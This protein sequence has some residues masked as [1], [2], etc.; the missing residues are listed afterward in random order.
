MA[1][2]KTSSSSWY[3]QLSQMLAQAAESSQSKRLDRSSVPA[4]VALVGVGNELN[5]DDAAG[6]WVARKLIATRRFPAH[7]LAIDGGSLPENASG[8]LRRFQPDLVLL[9]DA[10]E[11][12]EP[13]GMIE[14]L[15]E[16]MIG[17]MS[18]SSHTLP[19]S[20]LGKYLQSELGCR[21]EYL[22]IQPL[23]IDY[24]QEMSDCVNEA[25]N[26]IVNEINHQFLGAE[27]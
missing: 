15:D 8:P 19:L 4:R 5:G 12:G 23:Q 11:L 22:G 16:T 3:K 17:G 20:V 2:T 13:V 27:K 25:V 21:V 24:L 9:V 6:I 26:C 1:V 14:W 10:A 18:A 7:F